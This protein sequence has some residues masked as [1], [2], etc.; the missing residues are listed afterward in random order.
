MSGICALIAGS[1]LAL[2]NGP[3]T[4]AWKHSVQQ[5]RWEED[6]QAENGRLVLVEARIRGAGAGMEAPPEAVFAEGA[7]HYRPALPPQSELHLA[8]SVF[9]GAYE[10][11]SE[12]VCRP[13]PVAI[14]GAVL[15]ACDAVRP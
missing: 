9:G 15:Q 7:W 2:S 5:L 11:C 14:G 4:L 8:D 12:G 13:L 10:V 1:V 6:W 3:M